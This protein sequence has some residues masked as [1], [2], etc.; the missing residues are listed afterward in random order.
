MEPIRLS[1]D[2][3]VKLLEMCKILFPEYAYNPETFNGG[4]VFHHHN[5]KNGMPYDRLS[6]YLLGFR[7][8]N[9]SDLFD[10]CDFC[11]HWYEFCMTYLFAAILNGRVVGSEWYD[12]FVKNEH[13]VDY[14]YELFLKFKS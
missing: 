4:I 7:T 12:I 1:D 8:D 13:P 9:D 14:L 5:G 10:M 6:E 2:Q 3:K 11:I